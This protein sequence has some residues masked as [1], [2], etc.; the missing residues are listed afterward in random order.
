MGNYYARPYL[1]EISRPPNE[2]ANQL[3]NLYEGSTKL[4]KDGRIAH[5]IN[6]EWLPLKIIISQTK[7]RRPF[8]RL[9]IFKITLF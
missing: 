3:I 9:M 4:E 1:A 5:L 8:L 7:L 2:N 6:F